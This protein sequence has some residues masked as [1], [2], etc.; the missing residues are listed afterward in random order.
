MRITQQLLQTVPTGH[1][2]QFN[3]YSMLVQRN[4]IEMTWKQYWFNQ[5][6][7][8][9]PSEWLHPFRQVFWDYDKKSCTKHHIRSEIK[10]IQGVGVFVNEAEC[11]SIEISQLHNVAH[12]PQ[13]DLFSTFGIAVLGMEE[14]AQKKLSRTQPLRMRRHHYL[15]L[16][17]IFNL[18]L[19]ILSLCRPSL[20]S[21]Q[22]RDNEN[23]CTAWNI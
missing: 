3:V 17:H 9:Q 8:C 7:I 14:R 21:H 15:K 6:F 20:S 5:Q 19:R 16:F 11:F 10:F 1:R 13:D 2:R 4:L 18:S 12:H 23:K 22:T